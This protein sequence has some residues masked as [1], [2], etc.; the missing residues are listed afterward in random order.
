MKKKTKQEMEVH[1]QVGSF[2]HP[3]PGVSRT[4]VFASHDDEGNSFFL[5]AFC[6]LEDVNLG[7]HNKLN[8]KVL[9]PEI[10]QTTEHDA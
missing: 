8:L 3:V 4:I 6:C 5:I 2:S 1:Q 9:E 7:K 10:K